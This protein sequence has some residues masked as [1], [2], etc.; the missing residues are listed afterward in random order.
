M[1]T[2]DN[3]NYNFIAGR[4][5]FLHYNY[6]KKGNLQRY[7]QVEPLPYDLSQVTSP[8]YIYYS[9]NDPISTAQVLHLIRVPYFWAFFFFLIL[10]GL[11]TSS[12]L[13]SSF[14]GDSIELS[15]TWFSILSTGNY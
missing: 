13:T 6:G 7:G 15:S 4:E 1:I 11:G 14:F 9:D 12:T 2:G 8:V 3:P 5:V 10:H